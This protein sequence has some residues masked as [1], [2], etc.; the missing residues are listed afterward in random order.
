MEYT[1]FY[2]T[3][4]S[5]EFKHRRLNLSYEECEKIC[6]AEGYTYYNIVDLTTYGADDLHLL[7]NVTLYEG[8]YYFPEEKIPYPKKEPKIMESLY[9][10]FVWDKD[11][12]NDE[13][14][15]EEIYKGKEE[16]T[17][18]VVIKFPQFN[19]MDEVGIVAQ[20]MIEDLPKFLEDLEKNKQAVYINADYSPF[21]WLAWIQ[22]DKVRL[23]HQDYG[24]SD[25]L[26]EFDIL[27]DKEKFIHLCHNILKNME[28]TIQ[29]DLKRYE[30][31]IKEKYKNN[32]KVCYNKNVR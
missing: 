29:A 27:I 28:E 17:T 11:Y 5:D 1:I 13:Q 4:D 12:A 21:K 3:K 20:Y 15:Y 19:T 10:S 6:K 2:K 25:I 8:K 24:D 18:T 22:A 14:D 23:I 30:K 9:L 26:E 16:F 7:T 31:Y 32:Y